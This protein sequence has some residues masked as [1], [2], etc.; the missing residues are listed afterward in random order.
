MIT[1]KMTFSKSTKNTHVYLSDNHDDPISTV[2][3]QRSELPKEPPQV[4]KVTIEW[5]EG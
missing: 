5:S 1:V 4:I 2:Y 3:I